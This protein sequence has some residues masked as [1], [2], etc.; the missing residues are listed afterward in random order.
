MNINRL[1]IHWPSFT[2]GSCFAT[3]LTCVVIDPDVDASIPDE[4]WFVDTYF[5]H[6]KLYHKQG[7]VL[8]Y[9]FRMKNPK[10]VYEK[11]TKD[12]VFQQE[13]RKRIGFK[14]DS[15]LPEMFQVKPDTFKGYDRGHLVPARDMLYDSKAY[16]STFEMSNISPQVGKG[17]NRDYW[18]R[19]EDFARRLTKRYGVVHVITGPLYVPEVCFLVGGCM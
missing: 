12:K 14:V 11:L 5:K 19:L 15:S 8:S 6:E 16:E 1:S 7:Y 9:D 10:F 4:N 17:F 13:K 3:I 2:L 18:A